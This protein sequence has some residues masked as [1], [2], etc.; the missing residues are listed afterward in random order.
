MLVVSFK[1]D[2]ELSIL[3]YV[4][5][6]R[7]MFLLDRKYQLFKK[8]MR[9]DKQ[10]KLFINVQRQQAKKKN[11]LVTLQT[12]STELDPPANG[13]GLPNMN[14]L[15]GTFKQI[16]VVIIGLLY[17]PVSHVYRI[18]SHAVTTSDC[19]KL[20]HQLLKQTIKRNI[21]AIEKRK[22]VTESR[23]YRKQRQHLTKS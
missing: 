18:S 19:T 10:L 9:Y 15:K 20:H 16:L 1:R 21:D 22:T 17:I 14:I 12:T 13:F 23:H 6:D 5:S 4:N 11:S 8:N 3:I 7:A 2:E